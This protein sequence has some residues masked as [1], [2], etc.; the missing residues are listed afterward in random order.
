[1]SEVNKL[2]ARVYDLAQERQKLVY[3]VNKLDETIN[4]IHQEIAKIAEEEMIEKHE[5]SRTESTPHSN[6]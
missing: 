5:I 4:N 2:K 3:E 1:M 6:E